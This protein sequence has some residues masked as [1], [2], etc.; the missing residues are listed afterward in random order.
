MRKVESCINHNFRPASKHCKKCGS[1]LC[2]YCGHTING[3]DYCD[4]C[5]PDNVKSYRFK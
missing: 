3:D 5:Q 2:K 4:D 1:G